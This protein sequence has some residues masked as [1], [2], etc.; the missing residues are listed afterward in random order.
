M[1]SP[2]HRLSESTQATLLLCAHLVAAKV[3]DVSPLSLGEFND[4]V[5]A[6]GSR[7]RNVAELLDSAAANDL[8]QELHPQFD[9]DRLRAL[10]NRGFALS[11]SVEKWTAGGIW[12]ISRDD[13]VYPPRLSERLK[14]LAPALLYGCGDIEVMNTGGLAIVGSRDI[15]ESGIEFTNSIG[16]ACAREQLTVISGGARGVDQY[17]MLS[18]VQ[19]GGKVVGVMA[20][21]LA[22]STTSANARDA[23]REGRLTLVSPFDPEA[24]FNVGNAMS[25]NKAIYALADYGVVVTSGFNE[26]GTWSGAIEQLEKFKFVPVFV[27]TTG[28][29]PE[30]NSRLLKRGAIPFP[31]A[32]WSGLV[33]QLAAGAMTSSAREQMVQPPLF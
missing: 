11:L 29:V 2:N 23:I 16:E 3:K 27:R 1:A 30:G 4:L 17:A 20:D 5:A 19:A 22:R 9:T 6:L 32:P 28:N 25:R 7:Q 18:A 10:L 33:Q 26:G 21:S 12:V 13:A 14:K 24:G 15:D 31:P 8:L